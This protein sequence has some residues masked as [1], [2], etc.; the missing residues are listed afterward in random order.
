MKQLDSSLGWSSLLFCNPNKVITSY[1]GFRFERIKKK[2]T[3]NISSV[4]VIIWVSAYNKSVYKIKIEYRQFNPIHC[5][6][7]TILS[8]FFFSRRFGQRWIFK[9]AFGASHR[10]GRKSLSS[11]H[12]NFLEEFKLGLLFPLFHSVLPPLVLS[13]SEKKTLEVLSSEREVTI[14]SYIRSLKK[15]WLDRRLCR[16]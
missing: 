12:A 14:I 11:Q 3:K 2:T 4:S 5:S 8:R 10:Q 15:Y 13:T 1:V 7:D 16:I 9:L 6:L